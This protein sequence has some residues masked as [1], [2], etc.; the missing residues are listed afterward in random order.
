[1]L[2][3][4]WRKASRG[5]VEVNMDL[6]RCYSRK[7]FGTI[8]GYVAGLQILIPALPSDSNTLETTRLNQILLRG[9]LT[10]LEGTG[11]EHFV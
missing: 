1:M 11:L 10:S 4:G 9:G 8:R 2:P 3:V 6:R 7:L 5:T